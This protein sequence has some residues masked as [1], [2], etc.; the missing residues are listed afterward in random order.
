MKEET[1]KHIVNFRDKIDALG[2]RMKVNKKVNTSDINIGALYL[3][4]NDKQFVYDTTKYY[5][6]HFEEDGAEKSYIIMSLIIGEDFVDDD[7]YTMSHLDLLDFKNNN[8]EAQLW[9]EDG[10]YEIESNHFFFEHEGEQF[11]VPIEYT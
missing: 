8:L 4:V 2:V 3:R 10:D 7:L 9:I 1:W 5:Y 6:E 11:A